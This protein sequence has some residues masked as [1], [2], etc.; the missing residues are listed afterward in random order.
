MADSTAHHLVNQLIFTIISFQFSYKG[1]SQ[2]PGP[3][4]M[5]IRHREWTI[6]GSEEEWNL[7]SWAWRKSPRLIERFKIQNLVQ[8][9]IPIWAIQN[10]GLGHGFYRF[11]DHRFR[12][13][14]SQG[15][16]SFNLSQLVKKFYFLDSYVMS[17][18]SYFLTTALNALQFWQVVI[19][20]GGDK[21]LTST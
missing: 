16:N 18:N 5:P 17:H 3:V 8:S 1:F 19:A 13:L 20:T 6:Q 12:W 4:Y 14:T 7:R 11:I 9:F 15:K 21:A 10:F 2:S